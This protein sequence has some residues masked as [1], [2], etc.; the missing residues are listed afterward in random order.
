MN[1]PARFEQAV[2]GSFPF[3]Q[4]GYGVLARSSGCRPEWIA[5]LKAACQRYGER[6]AGTVEADALFAMRLG[7]GPWMIVGVFPQG[8]D[9]QG[10]PGALAFHALFVSRWTY[11]WAGADPFAFAGL[12]RRDWRLADQDANLCNSPR[13]IRR[14]SLRR[15]WGLVPSDND[16]R[17]LPIVEA[18]MQG[19]RVAVQ[20]AEPIDALARAVW[21]AL[22]CASG[23]GPR[24]PPG[25]LTTRTASTWPHYPRSRASG[26]SRPT[27]SSPETI[28]IADAFPSLAEPVPFDPVAMGT[29]QP[30][31]LLSCSISPRHWGTHGS[32]DGAASYKKTPGSAPC[33]SRLRPAIAG[34][35]FPMAW[36]Y[37]EPGVVSGCRSQLVLTERSLPP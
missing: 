14:A 37:W 36:T 20:S 3:W 1:V 24:S 33:R 22:P 26:A 9:D 21:R 6:P 2:Y 8:C 7:R 30:M 31:K 5:A 11:A 18:L 32:A 29:V 34:F 23:C 4:R 17:F 19:R 27:S 28:P 35:A 10:R 25:R 16:E 15:S 12:L 13:T